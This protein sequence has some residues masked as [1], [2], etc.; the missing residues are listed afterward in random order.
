[1]VRGGDGCEG[2]RVKVRGGEGC[3]GRE[4]VRGGVMVRGGDGCE[5]R[6]ES[7]RVRGGGKESEGER[8]EGVRGGE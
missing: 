8:R 4:K 7:V 6:P 1:M 2:R 5:G 3:E